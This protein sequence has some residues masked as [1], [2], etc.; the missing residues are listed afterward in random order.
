M[1]TA[2]TPEQAG[3]DTKY[4]RRF[5]ARLDRH[6]VNLHSVLMARGNAIFFEKYVSPFTKDTP[7]RMYSI[8]KSYAGLA[9]GL[10]ADEGKLSL[11]DPLISFFPDRVPGDVDPLLKEQTIRHMLRMQTCFANAASCSPEAM[12]DRV[13][14]YLRQKAD[15]YPGTLFDYDSAGSHLLGIIAENLSGKDLLSYLKEKLLNKLG[16][17]ENAQLLKT[18]DGH[19]WASS[20]LICK[21]RALANTVRFLLDGGV[22]EGERLLSEQFVRDATSR[23]TDNNLIGAPRYN[24]CGYGYQIWQAP[25]GAFS[26]NGMCSQFAVGIPDQDLIFV[27]TGD[28]QLTTA[29]SQPRIFDALYEEIAD[30]L[31]GAEPEEILP[32]LSA[33][34]SLPA[35]DGA[36]C[37]P[38]Q[39]MIDGKEFFCHNNPM[40]IR[41]FTLSWQ[42]RKAEF[43]Y[44]NE[45]GEK[46]LSFGM[47]E[48]AAGYFPQFGYSDDVGFEHRITSFRYRCYASA[49]WINA[50]DLQIRVQIVDR[51]FGRLTITFGFLDERHVTVRMIKEAQDF[52]NE[53]NGWM[54]AERR[55]M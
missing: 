40:G 33:A 29:D 50:K 45:Q 25:R 42:G 35:A 22:W 19:A 9:I 17:F 30:H 51:Y 43:R 24:R 54:M 23:L 47:N 2:C 55:G 4:L 5:M 10:L 28:T 44:E 37:V 7:H 18:P 49:G 13:G 20:A 21:P 26:F 36:E 38:L 15:K 41:K 6:A 1:F 34:A 31:D 53:Y 46:V 39:K 32:D 14:Y 52:L 11:D 16:D 48:N 27:C 12:Q 3:L 8:T